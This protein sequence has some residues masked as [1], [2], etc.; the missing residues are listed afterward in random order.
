MDYNTIGSS[1]IHCDWLD[2]TFP[3]DSPLLESAAG[4]LLE[5]GAPA[6]RITDDRVEYRLPHADWGNI[7]LERSPRGWGRLSASGGS[8]EALRAIS[9]FG[10]YLGLISEYPHTVTRLDACMDVLVPAQPIITALCSRYPPGS[11]VS[12]TRKG[13]PA[14][15]NL[16]PV[17]GGGFTGTFYAGD[18]RGS[19]RVMGRVY[20]KQAERAD[21][22][23]EI[24]PK[25][26]FE[27]VARK[28]TG[29]T[30]RDAYNP[31]ALFWHFASPALLSAPSDVLAWEPFTGESWA[32]GARPAVP[33]YERLARM[34]DA[35]V[36]IE[37]F[38]AFADQISGN[39]RASLLRLLQNRIGL[40]DLGKQNVVS[41]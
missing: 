10:P 31:A 32:L 33:D 11:L 28:D 27:I 12:L 3:A 36:D 39:G 30:L 13:V 2:V 9:A 14:R 20:D 40:R 35:S 22:G 4:F 19:A 8:C 26:R 6:R 18:I 41:A 34:V 29:I 16:Q 25:T 23:I 17:V 7:Q 5:H 38:C 24:G 1:P 15:Y 21:R 37:R